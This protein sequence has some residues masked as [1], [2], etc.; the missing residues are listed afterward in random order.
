MEDH[1]LTAVIEALLFIY[2]DPI[3]LKKMAEVLEGIDPDRIRTA[4]ERLMKGYESAG[5]GLQIVEIAGGYQIM[6]RAE[7]APWVR[8]LEKIKT[9]SRLS[10]SA[11]DALAIVT[12]K[13]PV[14]RG[15]I[16]AVRGVD[17]AYILKTLL[18]RRIIKIL[19][20][21]E[22]LGRPLLYG[23]TQDFLKYFGLKDLSELPALK[24]IK[25]MVNTPEE[26]EPARE[27]AGS[28]AEANL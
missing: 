15:E 16:D 6:T 7:C 27:P 25:E 12:Y 9:A 19:G 11:L 24:E 28:T 8:S 2:G 22:G 23:T 20:R 18:E 5:R 21:R 13:Q 3:P 14:T 10:R 4:M 26:F 1:E 17:S